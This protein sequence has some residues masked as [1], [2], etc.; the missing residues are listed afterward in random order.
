MT[1]TFREFMVDLGV[2][3]N[4]QIA[5]YGAEN[6]LAVFIYVNQSVELFDKYTNEIEAIVQEN[7]A[8]TYLWQQ[9]EGSTNRLKQNM[10]RYA[11]EYIANNLTEGDV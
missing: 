7:D 3:E 2:E 8:G 10:L 1:K 6:S 11:A 4:R 9:A 5:R